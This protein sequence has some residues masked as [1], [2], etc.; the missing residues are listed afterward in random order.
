MMHATPVDRG[1]DGGLEAA[2]ASRASIERLM[3]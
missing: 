1:V 3:A 2:T